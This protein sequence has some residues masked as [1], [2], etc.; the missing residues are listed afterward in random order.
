M[1][2]YKLGWVKGFC[3]ILEVRQEKIHLLRVFLPRSGSWRT[4]LDCVK[5]SSPD[6]LRGL[7]NRFTTLALSTISEFTLFSLADPDWSLIF[8]QPERNF[9][10]HLVSVRWS[11]APSTFAL[12]YVSVRTRK[13]LDYVARSSVQLS[14]LKRNEAKQNVSAHTLPQYYQPRL[15]PFTAWTVSVKLNK[16]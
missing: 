15:R 8:L 13:G 5:P 16:V 10:N 9:L 14:Y 11:S 6:A 4:I 2:K 1:I 12:S 7:L 3:N